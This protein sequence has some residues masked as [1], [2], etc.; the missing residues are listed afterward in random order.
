MAKDTYA[1]TQKKSLTRLNP[2]SFKRLLSRVRVECTAVVDSENVPRKIPGDITSV[3]R[4][5]QESRTYRHCGLAFAKYRSAARRSISKCTYVQVANGDGASLA[6]VSNLY[7]ARLHDVL[8][9]N[10]G[11]EKHKRIKKPYRTRQENEWTRNQWRF[12]NS[13]MQHFMA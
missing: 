10:A 7:P 6:S 4:S 11:G 3:A 5:I 9:S 12:E 8:E 1:P 2:R 13:M